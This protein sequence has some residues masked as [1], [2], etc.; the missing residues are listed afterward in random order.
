MH[1]SG[2]LQ[3]HTRETTPRRGRE[4]LMATQHIL[5]PVDFSGY[6]E[7]ALE[8]ASGLA[9]KL[10]A[11]LTL[12]HVIHMMPMGVA[13][14]TVLPYSYI[15]ELEAEAQQRLETYRQRIQ[16][17]GLEGT[18]LLVHGVPFQSIVD[19]ARDQNVDLIVMGTQGRTGLAHLFLGSVAEKVVR[20]APCPVLV[21]R[22]SAAQ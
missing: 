1:A 19:T 4:D 10:P 18:V 3:I 15:Q 7:Q 9:R 14:G 11:R 22:G 5:V 13:D 12:L 2:F 20:L 8:Y 17:A 6:A 21:T 16:E